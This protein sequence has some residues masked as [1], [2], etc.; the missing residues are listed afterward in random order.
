MMGIKTRHFRPLPDEISLEDLVPRGNLY[1]R[2][3][4]VLDISFV[5]ELVKDRYAAAGRPSVDPQTAMGHRVPLRQRDHQSGG[6]ALGER[7][8]RGAH[9]RERLEGHDRRQAGPECPPGHGPHE[10]PMPG[11]EQ[12]RAAEG[13]R[14]GGERT[15][16][17]GMGDRELVRGRNGDDARDHGQVEVGV[18]RAGHPAG[19]FGRSL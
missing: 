5:R 6:G 2:L 1:R 16:V 19:V 3:D 18:R 4:R 15:G 7:R 12:R 13:Q 11:H 9:R 10:G 17:A 14:D 8:N